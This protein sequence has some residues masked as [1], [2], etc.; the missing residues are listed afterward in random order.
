MARRRSRRSRRSRR[1]GRRRDTRHRRQ[2]GGTAP[3]S[4]ALPL[5][6]P[7]VLVTDKLKES[8]DKHSSPDEVPTVMRPQ[9]A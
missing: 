5:Q 3:G 9:T 1:L 8:E 6:F 2:I 4:A 7:G